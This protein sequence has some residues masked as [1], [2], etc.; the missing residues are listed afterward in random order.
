M[1][2]HTLKWPCNICKANSQWWN[3][4]IQRSN[5]ISR[6]GMLISKKWLEPEHISG[7]FRLTLTTEYHILTFPVF[8]LFVCVNVL[9]CF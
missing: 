7:A 8:P 2:F 9:Y 5:D 6:D 3:A 1:P 4:N